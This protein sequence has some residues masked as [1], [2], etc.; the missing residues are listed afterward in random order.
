MGTR[1]RRPGCCSSRLLLTR[2][3][4]PLAPVVT[5]THRLTRWF[6]LGQRRLAAPFPLRAT[7]AGGTGRAAETTVRWNDRA[8]ERRKLRPPGRNAV[9]SGP[10][11]HPVTH[12]SRPLTAESAR[13]HAR[14]GTWAPSPTD[15]GL[16]YLTPAG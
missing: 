5:V 7:A 3:Q 15:P 16:P 1:D 8:V 13:A 14:G 2:A 10:A 12:S 4:G 6:P 9:P 11:A